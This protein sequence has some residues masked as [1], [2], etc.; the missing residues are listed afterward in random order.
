MAAGLAPDVHHKVAPVDMLE[1]A[2]VYKGLKRRC[3]Y[4]IPKLSPDELKQDEKEMIWRAVHLPV[5]EFAELLG[6]NVI[7]ARLRP[8]VLLYV[9]AVELIQVR[10]LNNAKLYVRG[11]TCRERTSRNGP[12]K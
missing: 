10:A 9:G 1:V 5:K 8:T 12:V 4:T 7:P 3:Y 6:Q 2:K 11:F